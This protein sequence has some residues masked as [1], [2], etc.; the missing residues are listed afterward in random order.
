MVG[1]SGQDR[2]RLWVLPKFIQDLLVVKEEYHSK[3]ADALRAPTS[4]QPVQGDPTWELP[5][6]LLITLQYVDK[7]VA[8]GTA[9]VCGRE[10]G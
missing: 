2:P 4:T 6:A 1:Q 9:A 10:G 8:Q 5:W 3:A 7:K